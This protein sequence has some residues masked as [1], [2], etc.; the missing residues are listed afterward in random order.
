MRPIRAATASGRTV[1]PTTDPFWAFVTSLQN[2]GGA[3]GAVVF[4]DEKGIVWTPSGNAQ[5]DTSLGYNAALFDGLGDRLSAPGT[6]AGL[7]LS[8]SAKWTQEFWVVTNG[9]G[10]YQLLGNLNDADG[11]GHYW[12]ILNSTF[13]G[14]HTVQF[15]AS[16]QTLKFGTTALPT[17]ALTHIE[18]GFDADPTTPRL[19]CFINGSLTG[20]PLALAALSANTREFLIGSGWNS[21]TGYVPYNFNGWMKARRTTKGVCRHTSDFIPPPAPVPTS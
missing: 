9:T 2:F 3:D 6:S 20:S 12:I 13:T 7:Q 21:S 16:G 8:N 1:I 17:G 19:R 15:G 10:T 18:L 14:L 4:T 11:S 5:I